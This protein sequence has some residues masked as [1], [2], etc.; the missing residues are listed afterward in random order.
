M[1]VYIEYAF[2]Q[3]FFLDGGLLWLSH[4]VIKTP[5]NRKRILLSSLFGAIFAVLYPL[6]RLPSLL[7]TVLKIA[8]GCLLCMLAFGRIKSKK[9]RRGYFLFTTV[10]FSWSFLFGGALNG[11]TQGISPDYVKTV[12]TPLGFLV[13]SVFCVY[14][15]RKLYKRS[16]IL[17]Q[18]YDCVIR[19]GEKEA[20]AQGFLDSGNMVTKKGIPVCFVS[21]EIIYRLWGGEILF[22][23]KGEG[24]VRD[25]VAITTMTGSKKV[26]LYKGSLQ[27][28]AGEKRKEIKEVYFA[29]S[30]NMISRE[31][32]MILHSRI[33]DEG[34]EV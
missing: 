33:F 21:P 18:V 4:K 8:A 10:F 31:Y 2:L 26:L 28:I 24:Q 32:M 1:T 6:L 3:N 14:F 11:V 29:P 12:L 15:S 20:A 16:S 13:L 19:N 17:R 22:S 7:G 9:E 34:E 23:E 25:E 5:I 30:A 27:I